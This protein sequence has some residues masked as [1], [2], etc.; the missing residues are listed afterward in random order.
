MG[1]SGGRR[2]AGRGFPTSQ[3]VTPGSG[4]WVETRRPARTSSDRGVEVEGCARGRRRRSLVGR[5]PVSGVSPIILGGRSLFRAML[6]RL[7]FPGDATLVSRKRRRPV[8]TRAARQC[9]S[10]S[11]RISNRAPITAFPPSKTIRSWRAPLA[12]GHTRPR[13]RWHLPLRK[14]IRSSR[15]S[16]AAS[17]ARVSATFVRTLE[18]RLGHTSHPN[19]SRRAVLARARASG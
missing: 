5:A 14:M 15:W 17:S 2:S 13:S 4:G 8:L 6:T 1:S 16:S 7:R 19:F 11:A 18:V 9:E 3:K 12:R 10:R